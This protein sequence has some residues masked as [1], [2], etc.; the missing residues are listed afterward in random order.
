[1]K[2]AKNKTLGAAR[3]MEGRGE[4]LPAQF[5]EITA[6][7]ERVLSVIAIA[8]LRAEYE[9]TGNPLFLW[10]AIRASHARGEP[11]PTWAAT[12]LSEVADG[13]LKPRRGATSAKALRDALG[14]VGQRA[15]WTQVKAFRRRL[16]IAHA[17]AERVRSGK[18]VDAASEAAAK[19]F[20]LDFNHVR[21][22]YYKNRALIDVPLR[23]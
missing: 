9:E 22:T 11:T 20:A 13:L 1:M 23:P 8:G 6:Q 16:D 10:M 4:K 2:P 17:V 14:I 19:I 12:Y 21:N 5:A 15:P 3:S 18:T 7:A